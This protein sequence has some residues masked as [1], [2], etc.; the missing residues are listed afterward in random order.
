M[1]T[2][3]SRPPTGPAD[4]PT[5][6]VL[7]GTAEARALAAALQ[8]NGVTVLSSLAGR[9][10]DPALPV[11]AVRIGGFGGT[12]GLIEHLRT[13]RYAAVVDATHPFTA[14]MSGHAAAA[15]QVTGTPLLRLARPGWGTRPDAGSWRWVDSTSEA[16]VAARQ[17][18]R[19]AFLT[20]GRQTLDDFRVLADRVT[21]VRVVEPP[22]GTLPQRWEIIRD[23][24][25][26]RLAGEIELMTTRSLDVLVTKDSGGA[27]TS[28]KLDAAAR[29]DIPVIVV[30]RPATRPG[31]N[32]VATVEDAVAWIGASR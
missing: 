2:D 18:G 21:V 27:Y 9:V 12:A 6:L 23:R 28:A 22:E 32:A 29:L 20:T 14:T 16:A 24:G 1:P 3:W 7:G 4:E 5:V 26:Y 31:V 17:A 25:P 11:G 13:H 19:R 30:R 8:D 10:S 15:V